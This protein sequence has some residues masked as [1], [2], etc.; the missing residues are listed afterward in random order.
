V[1][2][3]GGP[4]AV[5]DANLFLGRLVPQFFPNI[6]GPNENEPLDVNATRQA[7]EKLAKEIESDPDREGAAKGMELDEMVYGFI[8]VANETMCRPIRALTE[9]RGFETGKHVYVHLSFRLLIMACS[10]SRRLASFGGAGG[11]HAC[12][13][14]RLLGIKTILIHRHSSILSAF[15][16]ALA[17]RAYEVQKPCS[18][19]FIAHSQENE[20]G[21]MNDNTL[22]RLT[23]KLDAMTS[24]VRRE[25]GKQG[26]KDS[27]NGSGEG[28]IEVE[29]ML[30]MRFEGTDTTLMILEDLSAQGDGKG[31]FDWVKEFKR[32]YKE[33]FGFLLEG[34]NV[35][36]DDI[37]VRNLD[38]L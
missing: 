38:S 18:E 10:Y 17:D 33:E 36:V 13:I 2:R 37:K 35:V 29:R 16:L 27:G 31:G 4:L 20:E 24:S 1:I 25:L 21:E 26:F 7:F 8:K 5:T 12:E 19:V 14:A 9:A 22:S 30:N 28:R 23:Q 6:F 34:S 15:G 11:Q 3:K 32:V